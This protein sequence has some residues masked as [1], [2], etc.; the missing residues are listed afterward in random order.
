MIDW[1]VGDIRTMPNE[2]TMP[3]KMAFE[4][5]HHRIMQTH[6]NIVAKLQRQDYKDF[7]KEAAIMQGA[8]YFDENSAPSFID[9]EDELETLDAVKLTPEEKKIIR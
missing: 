1:S 8:E 3:N 4:T 2:H 9:T 5:Q 7:V 6:P